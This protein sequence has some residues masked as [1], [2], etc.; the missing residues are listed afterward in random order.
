VGD[1]FVGKEVVLYGFLAEGLRRQEPA[2]V[3][4]TTRTS[5]E[6]ARALRDLVPQLDDHERSGRLMW[7][8]ASGAGVADPHRFATRGSDDLSGLTESLV[9]ASKLAVAS[10]PTGRFRV[11]FLGVSAVIGHGRDRESLAGLHRLL[12]V[13]RSH[14][15]LAMYALEAG[16][17]S[18]AHAEALLGRMDG[19]IVF[20]QERGRTLLAAR[21]FGGVATGDWVE[22]RASPRGLVL[23]SFALERIR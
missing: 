13:L 1:A 14:E 9:H 19:A 5:Q 15:A 18:D 8:D 2:I 22:C 3:I 10:S 17:I 16:A 23:G 20:R 21:G 4:T 11:G 12:G 7:I 6:V